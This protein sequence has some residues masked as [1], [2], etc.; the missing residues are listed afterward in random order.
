MEEEDKDD[1]HADVFLQV[2]QE[3]SQPTESGVN[4]DTV[5]NATTT[6]PVPVDNSN[7]CSYDW[8]IIQN[9]KCEHK[10]SENMREDSTDNEKGHS[11]VSD[12]Q[13]VKCEERPQ[14]LNEQ[15]AILPSVNTD[16]AST[17]TCDV[18]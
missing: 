6:F 5:S 13:S 12:L 3:D 11:I 7:D 16:L 15:H 8:K 17:W 18:N 1:V 10:L 4:Q 14:E 2:P 9:I